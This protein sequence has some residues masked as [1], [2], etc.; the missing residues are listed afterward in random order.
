[1]NYKYSMVMTRRIIVGVILATLVLATVAA[2]IPTQAADDGS[3]DFPSVADLQEGDLF[4]TADVSTVYYFGADEKRYG[5][6]NESTYFTWYD[7]FDDVVTISTEDMNL[8]PFAGMVTYFPHFDGMTD[9]RLLSIT[10]HD[11]VYV[12]LGLGML[13]AVESD[14]DADEMFGSDWVD[15]VDLL[16]DAF[17]PHYT[18]VGGD[19][20]Q[21]SEWDE[22]PEGGYSISDD[23]ELSSPVGVMIYTDPLRFAVSDESVCDS[24]YCAYN[25]ATVTQG[26]TVKFVNYTDQEITVREENNEWTTGPMA[27]G[28]IV[29]LTVNSEPGEYTFW[30]ESEDGLEEFFGILTV[31]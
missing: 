11:Q 27:V 20:D 6:P 22:L 17:I 13:I 9:T 31:E 1:M 12:S 3:L 7:D 19:V 21:N 5:F 4:K 8:I 10:G 16:P 23:K 30:G 26:K 24:D 14:S 28:D 29:V 25:E 2:A 15:R 18:I